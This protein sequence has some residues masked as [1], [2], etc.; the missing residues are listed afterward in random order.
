MM[1]VYW[2]T[3]EGENIHEFHVLR[4]TCESFLLEIWA[5]HAIP[6][7]VRSLHSAKVFSA[8]W[9]LLPDPRKFSPSKD[10]PVAPKGQMVAIIIYFGKTLSDSKGRFTIR[11]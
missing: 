9:S 1:T 5:Y 3:F 7:Y 10:S 4:A 8:K 6:T 2:K 11:R